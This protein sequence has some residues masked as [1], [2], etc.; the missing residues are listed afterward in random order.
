MTMLAPSLA[1]RRAVA[2]P[3]PL[4]APVIRA[5]FPA[6]DMALGFVGAIA[7]LMNTFDEYLEVSCIAGSYCRSK[8]FNLFLF[9]IIYHLTQSKY[10]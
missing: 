10:E 2:L 1:R 4:E 5:T 9:V 8:S 3:M 7:I 6:N